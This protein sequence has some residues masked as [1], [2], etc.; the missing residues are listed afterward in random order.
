[1]Y[2]QMMLFYTYIRELLL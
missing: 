1:M 2:V